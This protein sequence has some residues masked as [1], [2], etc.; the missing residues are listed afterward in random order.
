MCSKWHG[1]ASR[2]IVCSILISRGATCLAAV[3]SG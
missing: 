2:E 1:E 3:R